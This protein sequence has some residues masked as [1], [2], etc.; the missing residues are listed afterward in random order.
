MRPR[1]CPSAKRMPDLERRS[2][3][4]VAFRSKILRSREPVARRWRV[5]VMA[6]NDLARVHLAPDDEPALARALE[7]LR[8]K[9]LLICRHRGFSDADDVVQEVLMAATVG[10]RGGKF[11]GQSTLET[12]IYGILRNK[13]RD[14]ERIRRSD[15]ERLVPM[16]DQVDPGGNGGRQVC[17]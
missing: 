14:Y 10:F 3:A 9:L 17:V 16:G 7:A 15:S 8:P 6:A 2:D 1:P 11:R 12:W 4:I 13:I 5:R